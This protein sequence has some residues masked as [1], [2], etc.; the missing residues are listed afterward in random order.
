MTKEKDE[1]SL[2]ELLRQHAEESSNFRS[3]VKA[4]LAKIEV[5]AEYSK[6]EIETNK[7]DIETLKAAHNK[8]KGVLAVLSVVGLGGIEEF[9]RHWFTK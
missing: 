3:E 4:S 7:K 1:Y 5:H 2:R 6:K 8:Q 9:L